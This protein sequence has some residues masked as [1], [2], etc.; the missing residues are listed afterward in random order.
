[1]AI[2]VRD[3]MVIDADLSPNWHE[4]VIEISRI[5]DASN[6][7]FE[8]GLSTGQE[9][10]FKPAA[11]E[12]PLWDFQS[13]SLWQREYLAY[14]VLRN[15]EVKVPRIQF[16]ESSPFGAG[17]LIQ[18]VECEDFDAI[19][20]IE[21]DQVLDGGW[22]LSFNAIDVEGRSVGVWH[23]NISALRRICLADLVINNADRKA[24]HLLYSQGS[25]FA[26]DHGLSFHEDEKLRTFLWGW[27][28]EAFN[29]DEIR[30]LRSL[31]SQANLD[32][33]SKFLSESEI[34]ALNERIVRLLETA[35]FPY[36]PADRYFL[37]SPIF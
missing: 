23:R 26:I 16:V 28:G 2:Y 18:K 30:S 15:L 3:P 21:S 4:D 22:V 25:L 10:I 6:L 31:L 35:E 29:Q 20:I 37:P 33:A 5:E 19:Q 17:N 27:A 12:R 1:M 36:P 8:I 13:G 14:E 24:S 34:Q 7:V 11:G 9:F 32:L